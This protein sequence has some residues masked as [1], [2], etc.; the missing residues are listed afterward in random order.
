ML[1]VTG[2]SYTC[3]NVHICYSVAYLVFRPNRAPPLAIVL[4]RQV[5]SSHLPSLLLSLPL[6]SFEIHKGVNDALID[7]TAILN[8]A[9]I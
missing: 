3:G 1:V 8:G 6:S 4:R 2:G 9:F 7:E 5:L